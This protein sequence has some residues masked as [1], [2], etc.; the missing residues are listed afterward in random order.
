MQVLHR[1]DM[2]TSGVMLFAKE[3]HVVAD[4]HA[5]FR[6]R[7]VSKTY[8]AICLGSPALD[9]QIQRLTT[10]AKDGKN[11]MAWSVNVPLG[12]HSQIPTAGCVTHTGKRA[13]THILVREDN[14]NMAWLEGR[15]G[16]AWS[17]PD[18]QTMHGACLLECNPVTGAVPPGSCLHMFMQH[19]HVHRSLDDL[20]QGD[21]WPQQKTI[22][23]AHAPP[24]SNIN[25]KILAMKRCVQAVFPL[26]HVVANRTW[27]AWPT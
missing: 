25:I 2:D 24:A 14:R 15:L 1:L 12:Q 8:I 10:A 27:P 19:H 6:S 17:Q 3:P 22:R 26:P 18:H 7:T 16:E 23:K 9:G 4:M 13:S 21:L 20:Q 5:Q 11:N